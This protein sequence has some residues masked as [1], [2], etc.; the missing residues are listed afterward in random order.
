MDKFS[1]AVIMLNQIIPLMIKIYSSK[2]AEH[3]AAN[4]TF[5]NCS[6]RRLDTR[7]GARNLLPG[8]L[9]PPYP[10]LNLVS[11]ALENFHGGLNHSTPGAVTD[12]I[13]AYPGH[14]RL[15]CNGR[16]T[17]PIWICV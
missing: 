11:Y 1:I 7:G 10:I 16:D 9:S 14:V 8:G 12:S 5:M 15:C 17:H 4:S 13:H 6:I 3:R 2:W